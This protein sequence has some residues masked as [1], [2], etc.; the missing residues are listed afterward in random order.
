MPFRGIKTLPVEEYFA[1]GHELCP[2]CAAPIIVRLITKIAGKK[3]I[4]VSPTG[5]LEVSSTLYP[6]TAW[7]VPWM[8]F[9]F[10]NAA[11]VASGIAAAYEVFK[12]KYG[13]QKDV[14]PIVIA[15]DGG[16]A[17]IGFQA[18]SGA[19]ERGDNITYVCYD[20]EA[21]MNTG[22]Q[23][24]GTTPF[25]ART[26][27]T[28]LGNRLYEGWRWKKDLFGIAV[29]H[30]VTYAAT[31][32]VSHIIDAANKIEKSIN[33]EGPS[34]IHFL[35]PCIPGWRIQTNDTIKIARLAVQTGLWPLLEYEN[36]KVRL[37]VPVVRRKPVIEYLKL[38]G[39]FRH[40][41]K[42][43]ELIKML[44]R[45]ADEIAQIYGLGPVVEEVAKSKTKE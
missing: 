40:L 42:N 36:R 24:S 7:K 23:R 28:P 10:E 22:I 4:L 33:C 2:G 5:C 1:P 14:R 43:D 17:D 41:L 6:R 13:F 12:K 9:L 29:A 32:S 3:G 25:G 45:H 35:S 15:G 31:A 21:Y 38:Q 11:A 8:H 16:T 20:N 44:Q 19:F 39:R 30:N 34:F 18:L 27:T 37:T 26:T